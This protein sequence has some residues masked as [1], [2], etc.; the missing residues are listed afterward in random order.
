M[1]DLIRSVCGPENNPGIRVSW[2]WAVEN[3]R[4]LIIIEYETG[5]GEHKRVAEI[6]KGAWD[7]LDKEL[8]YEILEA[9]RQ[10]CG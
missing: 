4:H 2:R 10:V 7:A 9:F 5:M 3:N 8:R 1:D 6:D